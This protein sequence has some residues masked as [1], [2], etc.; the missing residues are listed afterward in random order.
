[1]IKRLLLGI[2][3][4]AV[5]GVQ[6]ASALSDFEQQ[7]LWESRFGGMWLD[8]KGTHILIT[9]DNMQRNTSKRV[10]S[11]TV[12][13]LENDGAWI[14]LA[15]CE[16]IGANYVVR[17]KS[18]ETVG[19]WLSREVAGEADEGMAILYAQFTVVDWSP[20]RYISNL[21]IRVRCIVLHPGF[22]DIDVTLEEPKDNI[23]LSFGNAPMT[24]PQLHKPEI[25]GYEILGDG[26]IEVKTNI[27]NFGDGFDDWGCDNHTELSL[28]QNNSVVVLPPQYV[29][30]QTNNVDL[31]RTRTQYATSM[32]LKVKTAR[33][34]YYK[35]PFEDEMSCT[36]QDEWD[37]KVV[38]HDLYNLP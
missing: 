13:Y 34:D 19:W 1:M 25:T 16:W 6:S 35:L 23:P 32:E 7:V 30:G 14:E 4:F 33:T 26:T 27:P 31:P 37:N 28:L 38:V 24:K 2:V 8:I 29:A 18:D 21:K 5:C 17:T 20:N 11:A 15:H 36:R 9:H 10:K 22:N 12:E 3:L